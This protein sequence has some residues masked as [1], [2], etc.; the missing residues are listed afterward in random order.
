LLRLG[1]RH[2]SEDATQ[3][4]MLR[5]YE[6]VRRKRIPGEPL[7]WLLAIARRCCQ[8]SQRQRKRSTARPLREEDGLAAAHALR[9]EAVDLRDAI[10]TL[11]DFEAVVLQLKHTSGL[12]CRQISEQLGKPI[13]TVTAALSRAYAKL[14]AKYDREAAE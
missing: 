14:R 9:S 6:Q 8:E 4:A 3:E 13:G 5:L 12:R 2:G 7:P 11:G 10:G 1:D